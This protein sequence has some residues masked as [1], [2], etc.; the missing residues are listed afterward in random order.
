MQNGSVE[1]IEMQI[2]KRRRKT[3]AYNEARQWEESI[4]DD[5]DKQ[6]DQREDKE[7]NATGGEWV[8]SRRKEHVR[9]LDDHTHPGGLQRLGDGHGDL[10]GQPL[11]NW[12]SNNIGLDG[13]NG[14]DATIGGR[15]HVRDLT[16]EPSAVDLYNPAEKQEI[17]WK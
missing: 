9:G 4:R 16:L 8:Q 13:T 3:R 1:A 14:L 15:E 7:G 17:F 2:E 11:L 10:F 12:R 6:S 5:T